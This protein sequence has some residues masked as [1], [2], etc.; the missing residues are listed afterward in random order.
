VAHALL[1]NIIQKTAFPAKAGTYSSTAQSRDK[2]I[3]AFAGNADF[4]FATP[5]PQSTVTS[6]KA[7]YE[8]P[9]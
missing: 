2:W 9:K 3:R 7:A 4:Q 6:D 8:V 1:R 5:F